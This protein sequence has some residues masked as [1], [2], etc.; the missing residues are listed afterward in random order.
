MTVQ[1]NRVNDWENPRVT[2]RNK[3][4][5]HITPVIFSDETMALTGQRDRSPYWRSLN[6]SWRF[7]WAP[8]P[9]AAP[10]GFEAVD[11]DDAEWDAIPVPANWQLHGYDVPMYTNVQYPFP[12]DNLPGVPHDDNPVGSYRATFSV[13]MKWDG[14]RVFI[15]FEGVESAFY[16]WVNGQEVGYSQDSRL[17]AE[18]DITPYV[19]A[20]KNVLAL[21]VYRWSDGSYLE[22]QDHWRLSGIH[23]D[24]Y[25][26]STPPVHVRDFRVR[27]ALDDAYQDAVLQVRAH[28]AAYAGGTGEHTL[29]IRLRDAE[30][31]SVEGAP[32]KVSVAPQPGQEAVV[33]LEWPLEAPHKWSAEDPYLYDLLMTLRDAEGTVVEVQ[34]AKVGFRRVEIADAQLMVNGKPVTIGGV[35]RHDHDPDT[36][37]VVSREAMLADVLLMKRHNVNA[38]RTSHY[39]NDPYFLD[40][41]DRYGL[42]VFDEANLESHG[43]WDRLSNDP[44]WHDA[45]M[46]RAIR[47]VE[48]DKNHPSVIVWSLGNESGYGPNHAAMADW[49]HENDPTRPVHY[50]PAEDAPTVDILAPMYPPVDRII[51]MAQV[52]GETRPVI[53]CEYAHSMGNSTGNLKEYWQA[54]REHPRLQG[55]FI[56]DW[57]DQG[58]RQRTP[59]GV[60]WFAYGGDFG[61]EPNDGNFCLNGLVGPDRTPHPALLEYKKILQPVWVEEEDLQSFRVRVTNRYMFSDLGHLRPICRLMADDRMLQER[62]L[63]L[64]DLA[65]GESATAIVPVSP[66]RLTPGTE[67]WLSFHFMLGKATPWGKVD[68]EVASEQIKLPWRAPDAPALR[69]ADM[70][71]VQVAED[72]DSIRVSGEEFEVAF[73]REA[74]RMTSFRQGERELVAGG[75]RLNLW[76]APTDNDANTWGDQKAAIRWRDAG[77]DCLEETV[78]DVSIEEVSPQVARVTVRTALVPRPPEGM[79]ASEQWQGMLGQFIHGMVEFAD[80]PGLRALSQSLG[81]DYDA[82][83]G[84]SKEARLRAMVAALDAENRIHELL[85]ATYQA[86]AAQPDDH[87]ASR[88]RQ[89]LEPVQGMN[90]DELRAAFA[91]KY[92]ARF[93]CTYTYTVYGSGDVL[94]DTHV[95]PGD[96]LPPLPRVGLTMTLLGGY[97]TFTWYGRGPHESYVDR[98]ESAMVGVYRGTVDEQYVPYVVPQ[99][100]GN[101]TDVRWVAL[102]NADGAGLLASAAPDEVMEVSAH[103]FTAGDL[104]RA[105]HTHE[106]ARRDEITLNLDYRQSGLG[107]ASC[108][109]GTLPQY[110]LQPGEVRYTVR[111]RPLAAGESPVAV[112]KQRI[113]G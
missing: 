93:D 12:I 54:I 35:N 83:P 102:T 40:L 67:Y 63:I 70:P 29:E 110:L 48:R 71:A 41:C 66:P 68:H 2:G 76:R 45:F 3:E 89:A 28:V 11:W 18:F 7:F 87:G 61:D 106:L 46:E 82:L 94:V 75:P 32:E 9:D 98:K 107:S 77:L 88:I 8:N 85:H 103:H 10:Q 62:T 42:Y 27:T 64:P 44:E 5:G 19:Q 59:E 95:L 47:M 15:V 6:G 56:W 26:Y 13:P 16:L 57:M 86:M 55:G 17:P 108:G 65:P 38:V 52:P 50:H 81:L 90:T 23:R 4:P 30:G 36:G 43:V 84:R 69:P 96:D 37:K 72:G 104:T 111:L 74:G 105:K 79:A 24:V 21:R 53:M 78:Q 100:N 60:E 58:L 113:A 97:E 1:E 80:E 14:R 33:D 22:D 49:I 92:N 34:S 73:S 109:P 39:P 31:E 25:I 51:A 99:E 101:K 112:G 91:P 20:G